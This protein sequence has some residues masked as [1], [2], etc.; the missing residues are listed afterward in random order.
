MLWLCGVEAFVSAR[1]AA[2]VEK[3]GV[4]RAEAVVAGAVGATH[5]IR[6][7]TAGATYYEGRYLSISIAPWKTPRIVTDSG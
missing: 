4:G 1:D 3:A 7:T 2:W 5:K 6:Q